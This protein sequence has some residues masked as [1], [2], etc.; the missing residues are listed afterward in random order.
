MSELSESARSEIGGWHGEE[1]WFH[2]GNR[3]YE[4]LAVQLVD[5]GLSEEDALSILGRADGITSNE[6]GM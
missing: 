1:G 2:N 6:F 5:Y 4:K 3:D